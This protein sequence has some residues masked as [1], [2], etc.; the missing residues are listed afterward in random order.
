MF[1]LSALCHRP[2]PLNFRNLQRSSQK[3]RGTG[4][5]MPESFK[6]FLAEKGGSRTLREPYDSQ[7]GFEDQRHHRA[8]SF[9]ISEINYLRDPYHGW[10]SLVHHSRV[11][12]LR[13]FISSI[14][15]HHHRRHRA[16]RPNPH[17]SRYIFP[18]HDAK[19]DSKQES[20]QCNSPQDSP[21]GAEEF[22]VFFSVFMLHV[23]I[24]T[25]SLASSPSRERRRNVLTLQVE[26][27]L[28]HHCGRVP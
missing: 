20:K 2:Q 25:R 8:P 15:R 12:H 11:H 26:V 18:Q 4:P 10:M 14:C 1:R 21:G 19:H 6:D 9:S 7:T 13:F 24:L 23:P 22:Q 28:V 27:A 3:I 5:L 17:S 16:S